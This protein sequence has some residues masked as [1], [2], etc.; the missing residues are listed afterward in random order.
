M[1]AWIIYDPRFLT[2]PDRASCYMSY[3][4]EDST[5]EEV[6]EDRKNDWP[7]GVIVEY[8]V[9]GGELKNERIIT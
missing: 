6:K 3:S 9:D 2:D 1:I 8:D 4:S 5:L 7:D